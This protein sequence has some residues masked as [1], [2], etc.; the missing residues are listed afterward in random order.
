MADKEIVNKSSEKI[1][2]V[3]QE[4]KP[5]NE[6]L[7]EASKATEEINNQFDT[8]IQL[9]NW[10]LI[11]F[12]KEEIGLFLGI[13][14]V[15]FFIKNL[16][17]S[18]ILSKLDNTQNTISEVKKLTINFFYLSNFFFAHIILY[19]QG[20]PFEAFKFVEWI[21][22]IGYF[23]FGVILINNLNKLFF[24]Y[25]YKSK[26]YKLQKVEAHFLSKI[27]S[28]FIYIIAFFFA[29]SMLGINVSLL[30][31][32][33]GFIGFAISFAA[34]E[35]IANFFGGIMVLLNK[36][37]DHGDWIYISDKEEG[38]VVETHFL[39]TTIRTFD[40]SLIHIPNSRLSSSS[41]RN[42]SKR[43]VGRRIKLNIGVLYNTNIEDLQNIVKDIRNYLENNPEIAKP[44]ESKTD[45]VQQ[46]DSEGVKETLLVNVDN[47]GASSIDIMVYC[48]SETVEWGEW[49]EVKQKVML[50]IIKIVRKNNSDFAFP[51]TTIDGDFLQKN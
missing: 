30:I 12:Y 29:L 34:K 9:F 21:L 37:F 25:L 26:K 39:T 45:L 17:S 7:E 8:F 15:L 4:K 48:F 44:T 43:V 19:F 32:S 42:W 2:E 24:R 18:K 5:T 38:T 40:N 41:I 46:K 22:F 13:F 3:V 14:F 10:D 23:V 49:L 47:F 1:V 6:I 11:T 28:F 31:G 50:E 51:T 27:V 20:F 33:L 16:I 36:S 35:S